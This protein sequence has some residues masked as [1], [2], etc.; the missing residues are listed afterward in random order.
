MPQLEYV[1]KYK[2]NTGLV[3][4]PNE[5][6]D[7]YLYGIDIRSKDGSEIPTYVWEQKIRAAQR[8]VE[9]FLS[10]KLV[11]QLFSEKLTYFRDDYLNNLPILNTSFPVFKTISLLGLLNN[12]EQIKYPVEWCNQYEASDELAMRRINIV[13]SGSA[14]GAATN[15][16]LMGVMAQLGIRSLNQVPNYWSAQYLTGY[17][18]DKIPPEIVDIVGKLAT[19]PILAIYGDLVLPPGLSGQSLSIDGLSQSLNTPISAQGGAFSGR[20]KQYTLEIK[21][22]L[23]QLERVYRGINFTVL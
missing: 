7:L 9:N 20:I 18:L 6:K 14:T 10:I 21:E 5:L 23:L 8:Q 4:S 2:K 15:V 22:A 1:T 19:I 11:R 13:P 12:I 3:L 16:V 17:A